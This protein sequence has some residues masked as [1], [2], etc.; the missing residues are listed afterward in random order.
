MHFIQRSVAFIGR[1]FL[2][3]IFISSGFHQIMNWPETRQILAN[4]LNDWTFISM[5]SPLF[6]DLF[7]QSLSSVTFLLGGAIFCQLIGGLSILLGIRVR[8]GAF[9]L[10]LFIV[11]VTVLFH[12]FWLMQ[13]PDRQAEMIEFMKNISILGGLLLLLAYGNCQKPKKHEPAESNKR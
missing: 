1:F 13:E 5:N 6:H 7:T 12:H 4:V 2:S 10:I 9:L 8:M 3:M 11:P